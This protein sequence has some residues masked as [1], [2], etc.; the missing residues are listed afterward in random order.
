[1]AKFTPSE[2][3]SINAFQAAGLFHPFTCDKCRT[4]LVA[5]EDGLFCPACPYTQ[6]WA[7]SFMSDWSWVPPEPTSSGDLLGVWRRW[8]NKKDENG[9]SFAAKIR[10]HLATTGRVGCVEPEKR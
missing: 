5:R 3:A 4:D 10:E 9:V 7:H 1:M 8:E 6:I 2:V